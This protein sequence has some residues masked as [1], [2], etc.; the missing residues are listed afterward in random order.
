MPINKEPASSL[1]KNQAPSSTLGLRSKIKLLPP[2]K[3]WW[4]KWQGLPRRSK[5][6]GGLAAILLV[7]LVGW[8][9]WPKGP[10]PLASAPEA[11]VVEPTTLPSPLT[12]L[13]VAREL[14][15]RPVTAIMI[16]NSLAARP[17]SGIGEA[18]VLFEAIAE[19]GITRFIS[20]FQESQPTYIGPV[21]SLRP[22]YIDWARAFDAGIAHI[23]G[24]PEALEQIRGG[25][26]KDLDQFFN[27]GS[28]WRQ[29]GRASPHNVYT[30]F[31]KLD[32]LNRAKGYTTSKFASWSRK[33][34]AAL[35]TPTAKAINLTV[36]STNYN[37]HYDYDASTNSYLRS[38]GGRP[39]IA[40]TSPSDANGQQLKPKIVIA[41][42]IPYNLAGRYSSYGVSSGGG[43][44]VFQDG[45]VT[46]GTWSKADR[47]SQFVFKDAAGKPLTF[48]A[49]QAW[50]TV[51]ADANRISYTP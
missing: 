2:P 43:V 24:S 3:H 29:A 32:A 48:N 20:L 44:I 13:Q 18:G 6:I 10:V 51:L 34:D 41:M 47:A 19:G 1:A 38:Q 25:A 4:Q 30:S 49:G 36:S 46:T 21:R 9:L 50:V 12:G 40:T 28:Y 22:Y 23:G 39:H 7:A 35:A 5:L 37:V 45:G 14:A 11:K 8:L 42:V 17:Q 15:K 26:A 33:A 31:E 27:P 16:E